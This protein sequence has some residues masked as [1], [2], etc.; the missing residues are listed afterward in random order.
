VPGNTTE[1]PGARRQAAGG[2]SV[3]PLIALCTGFFMVILDT[4]IVTVALP[5]IRHEFHSGGLS[6]V[7]WV[8]DGYTVA[9]AGLLLSAGSVG[10]RLGGRP[11]FQTG[12]AL[13]VA[14]SVGCGLAPDLGFLV[15]M[16]MLQG[17]AA[18]LVVP[19]SL[20][21]VHASYPERE[22]RARAIGVWGGIG[23]LA[24]AS[25]PV[26][27]GLLVAALG[28]RAVFYVNVPFGI[29]G[30]VLTARHVTA[31]RPARTGGLDLPGQ[32]LVVTA[33]GAAVYGIIEAGRSGPGG[34]GVVGAFA[35]AVVC[36]GG[37]VLVEYR[38]REPMLPPGLFRD[39]EFS[40][41]SL[42]GFLMNV[43]FYGQLFVMTFYFQEE[44]H[45]GVLWAGLALLPQTA[46]AAPASA[47]G[48]RTTARTGPRRPMAL[49]LTVGAAGFVALL[50]AGP[51]TPY[52]V[53]VLP[54]AAVGFGTAFTMP[55][56]TAAV[57]ESA[58]A[59]RAGV[60]SGVLNAGR[61]VGSAVGVA[62][63]GALV[64]GASG[65]RT[66]MR[67][68]AVISACCFAVGAAA[69]LSPRPGRRAVPGPGRRG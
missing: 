61:Q 64:T 4:T 56:A 33:L 16:R 55:A 66:G 23:G 44:R 12:L 3:W 53:L 28:W 8:V 59:E 2:A 15:A 65:F 10:D 31:P 24:A 38:S 19:T 11:A 51:G 25:G 17:V 46:I 22:Q 34:A 30:L 14:T 7:Q 60:A 69:A 52:P 57:V 32:F 68:G 47:W 49:G 42:V 40:S 6:G 9:F 37:F 43:G 1:I 36:G 39:A 63:L 45:Y 58:P 48:G 50:A 67:T 21:L 29:L 54:L 35:V 26:L 20:A 41:A 62:L 27:G 13:F 5:P 18:A